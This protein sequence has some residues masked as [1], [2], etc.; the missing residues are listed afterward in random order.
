MPLVAGPSLRRYDPDQVRRSAARGRPL[1]PIAG[2]RSGL[3]IVD[4]VTPR[5]RLAARPACTSSATPGRA[6]S[7]PRALRGGVDV[8]QL[9]DKALDDDGLRRRRARVPRG[10][11][12]RGAL[13]ILNDRPDLVA[14]AAPTACTSARTT[15]A[16]R[17]ARARPA[18][19]AIVG[20]ST[21]APEQAD[22]ADGDPDVDYLAVGPVHATPTKPGRP[23]AG[24]GLRRVR[25]RARAQ[26][27]VR[28]RRPRRR[29]RRRG[30]RARRDADRRR[31]R[32]HRGGRPG[33]RRAR[34]C[35]P[36]WRAAVGKRSRKAA[37]PAALRDRRRPPPRGYARSR[38]RDEA[39]RAALE[40]LAPG[41]RP[42]AV[43]VA[44]VV[45]GV[46]GV[47]NLALLLAGWDVAVEDPNLGG[48]LAVSRRCSSP[49]RRDVARA[50]LGGARLR[51]AARRR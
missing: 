43:T 14:A 35:G 6:S 2:S 26:A 15:A 38:E 30:G 47:A 10:R 31:A 32:D 34:R 24:L 4:A 39:I 36:R 29:Q 50:V 11:R 1:S 40:P 9:R 17:R 33:G 48:A 13:F 27:V 51:G 23:A 16:R 42:R 25:G 12:R 3:A 8:F 49:P 45:A 21:H 44:A 37:R 5:E 41:E 20:R 46:L 18:P 28:D 19:D 22:A 7:S